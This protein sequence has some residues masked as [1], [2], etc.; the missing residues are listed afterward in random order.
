MKKALICL[1]TITIATIATFAGVGCSGDSS[2]AKEID[3]VFSELDK[4]EPSGKLDDYSSKE[5]ILD[6]LADGIKKMRSVDTSRCPQD[7]RVAYEELMIS[8]ENFHTV[9]QMYM[10]TGLLD[11]LFGGSSKFRE[12]GKP[13]WERVLKASDNLNLVAAR[14]GAKGRLTEFEE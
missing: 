7:F 11:S 8:L 14:Y 5:E 12:V 3:K 6:F 13:A 4:M 9:V 2:K 1:L 10:P